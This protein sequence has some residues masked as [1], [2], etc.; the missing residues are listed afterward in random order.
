[1]K[2]QLL[3]RPYDFRLTTSWRKRGRVVD[4][5]IRPSRC[6]TPDCCRESH[7]IP[8]LGQQGR[9]PHAGLRILVN[10]QRFQKSTAQR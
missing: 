1:M 8:D 2:R 9:A 3:S 4:V 10:S 5:V 6:P 7:A